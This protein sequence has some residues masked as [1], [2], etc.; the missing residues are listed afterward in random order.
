VENWRELVTSQIYFKAMPMALFVK[1]MQASLAQ[2][3]PS[4][5]FTV[6]RQDEK[7]AVV[8]WRDAGCG[9]FE[10]SSELARYA[11]EQDGLYRL[12]YTVKGPIAPAQ[13]KQWMTILER[14]PLA[15]RAA[16][17]RREARPGAHDPERAAV[18]AKVTQ[19]LAG[20]VRQ[21]GQPCT[22]PTAEMTEQ[23][24]GPAG[25]LTEWSLECSEAAYTILVQPN[26]A[27][28]SIRR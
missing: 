22:K 10:P 9:G 2:G 18:I 26:G 19:I 21:G 4:L 14:S 5:V 11:I 16:N 6:I 24:P 15:E 13:R 27:M 1:R 17:P 12:A 28:T 3:C 8:E 20:F 7:S 25:P 23:I